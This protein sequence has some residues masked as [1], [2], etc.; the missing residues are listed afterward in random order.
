M[1]ET[2][3][4]TPAL[5]KQVD[6][7]ENAA[8][9]NGRRRIGLVLAVLILSGVLTA[10]WLWY[11]SKVELT[12]DDAFIESHIHLISARVSGQVA[13]IAVADNQKVAAGDLL[14]V[15]DPAR[16][17]AQVA[18]AE[19]LLAQARNT[20][21]ENQAIIGAQEAAV[22][23]ARARL[24]QAKTDL[25]RG[26]ALFAHEVIPQERLD[27]L[28]TAQRVAQATLEQAR[29][30][31]HAAKAKLGDAGVGGEQAKIA[32]RTAELEL[33]KLN[34]AYTRI[35]APVAG[36]VTRKSVQVG[37]NIQTGQPLLA[38]VAL[39]NPW[40][41]ANYK[42]SQLTHLEPGQR[43]DFR[44]DSY[45]GQIFSGRVDSIMAGTGAAFSLLPPENASGNYV[46]VVQRVPVK[47]SIDPS[48]DPQH[49][50]R[51][52]MSVQ[53]TIYTGRSLG[54]IL[55]TLDPFN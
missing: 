4:Q 20:T 30:E 9:G 35:F 16:Y 11:K 33:A 50:L 40:I 43:V 46:K 22:N 25:Q 8:K 26:T 5:T 49:Q 1:S 27:Q 23:Q 52:G 31:L 29:Q 44:V 48:S 12:T 6:N 54:D 10:S 38:L 39:D 41:I 47:I 19:A 2:D 37:N 24:S 17:Q 45:P 42:E 53:P 32:E 15:L 3:N 36:Y 7:N 55:A 18:K 51:I 13:T 34:L 14:V 28:K 21:G